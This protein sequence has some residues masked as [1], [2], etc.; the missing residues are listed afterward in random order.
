MRVMTRQGEGES[1]V[2]GGD[3]T[4]ARGEEGGATVTS[5]VE[6]MLFN[7]TLEFYGAAAGVID[8]GAETE[9]PGV[10]LDLP[11]LHQVRLAMGM[12]ERRIALADRAGFPL[13]R[14]I[15]VTRLDPDVVEGILRR[16]RAAHASQPAPSGAAG[17]VASVRPL[18]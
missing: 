12:L 15:A 8:V 14:I 13:E 6:R 1:A 3:G 18:R 10:R 16:H 5:A 2:D 9:R 7:A 11:G 17:A 4:G